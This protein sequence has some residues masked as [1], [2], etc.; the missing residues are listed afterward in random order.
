[1]CLK[2]IVFLKRARILGFGTLSRTLRIGDEVCEWEVEVRDIRSIT[3]LSDR[4]CRTYV[5]NCD[6]DVGT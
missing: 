3:K 5:C 1:M 4:R 6:T 2:D